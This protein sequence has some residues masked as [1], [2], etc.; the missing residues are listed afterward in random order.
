MSRLLFVEDIQDFIEPFME[1]LSVENGQYSYEIIEFKNV[2]E[3]I[4][5]FSPDI[6][7]L[8]LLEGNEESPGVDIFDEIWRRK[9][10]PV[11]V[12]SAQPDRIQE[13]K[14]N[15]PFIDTIKKGRGS[16]EKL[17]VSIAKYTPYAIALRQAEDRFRAYFAETIRK[18]APMVFENHETQ[19]E[20]SDAIVRTGRRRLA[21][22]LD[23]PESIGEKIA[24]WEQYIYPPV[25]GGVRLGDVYRLKDGDPEDP[26]S[27][28]V[29]LT[30]SCDLVASS[31]RKPKTKAVLFAKC[32]SVGDAL[33]LAGLG[34]MKNEDKLT[35]TIL[36]RGYYESII[37]FPSLKGA[38]PTMF[39]N[40]KDLELVP[41]GDDGVLQAEMVKAASIDSPFREMISWAYLNTACR[42]GMPDRD[43]PKWSAEIFQ[44]K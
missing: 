26:T 20:Q 44:A 28:R 29:V 30:P 38:I 24:S 23:D 12:Y 37:P 6:I 41:I 32:L 40:V 7:I 42:P 5:S 15:H 25:T 27:F 19:E 34:S 10:C 21:A 43:F 11:I 3:K 9:Y 22:W 8:D 31:T 39:A 18:V 14:Q 2:L 17:V 33:N 35:Q 16:E 1:R 4:E 36:T 13:E